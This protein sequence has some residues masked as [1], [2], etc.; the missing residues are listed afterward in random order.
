[1]RPMPT[2][3]ADGMAASGGVKP[4]GLEFL[5]RSVGRTGRRSTEDEVARGI[6]DEGLGVEVLT[7]ALRKLFPR[8]TS[9]AV[10]S[11]SHYVAGQ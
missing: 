5:S 6:H 1:M 10:Q 11:I 7:A 2:D 4:F 8:R 3:M 9:F